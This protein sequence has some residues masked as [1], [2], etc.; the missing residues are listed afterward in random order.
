MEKYVKEYDIRSYESNVDGQLRLRTLFNWFQDMADTH[1][2][3]M[4]LGY[5]YCIE[6]GIGWI[7]GGYHVLIN[8]LPSWG[9]KVKLLTWPSAST[10]A[11]GIREFQMVAQTGEI[12]VNA[13]SQWVLVDLQRMRPVS[14]VKHIPHYELITERVVDTAFPPIEA[15]T[16]ADTCHDIPVRFD[17][18]DINK[19][20][21]NAVYP[22]LLQDAFPTDFWKKCWLSEL[23]ILFKLPAKTGDIIRLESNIKQDESYH[24]MIDAVNGRLFARARMV[25]HMKKD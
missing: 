3:Q 1:A 19:H 9:E 13:S 24:Q 22:A 7:G 21:N 6:R 4:G 25:W 17:D 10:A 20:V 12:L 18:I 16:E 14:V 15:V 2:D 23:Q 8:R 5:H 11:T